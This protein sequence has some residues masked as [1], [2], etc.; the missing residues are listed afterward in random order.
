MGDN[1]IKS[2]SY[3]YEFTTRKAC[4]P[5][6]FNRR[7]FLWFD[8]RDMSEANPENSATR[9]AHDQWHKIAALLMQKLGTTHTVITVPEIQQLAEDGMCNVVI[10][11]LQD[12]IHLRLV[13]EAEAQLLLNNPHNV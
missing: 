12:G 6:A 13:D 5:P 4:P 1:V 3:R 2:D 10:Q 8:Y 11:E 9:A 7:G